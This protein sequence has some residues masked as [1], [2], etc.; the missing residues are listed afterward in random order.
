MLKIS[1]K[2]KP[3]ILQK[4]SLLSVNQKELNS[5]VLVLSLS[6]SLHYLSY[7]KK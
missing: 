2:W 7:E 6:Y 5:A 1:Q 4:K 3:I